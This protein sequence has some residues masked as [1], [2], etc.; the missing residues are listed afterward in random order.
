M[1][2]AFPS[3]ELEPELPL[4]LVPGPGPELVPG[5]VPLLELALRPVLVLDDELEQQPERAS[6][7]AAVAVAGRSGVERRGVSVVVAVVA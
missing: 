4:V 3:A 6:S 2:A 7:A 5:H 1:L